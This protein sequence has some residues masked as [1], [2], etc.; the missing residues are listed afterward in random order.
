MGFTGGIQ[1]L[2][3]GGIAYCLRCAGM[4]ESVALGSCVDW[5]IEKVYTK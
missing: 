1:A 2:V 4:I 3:L 5:I